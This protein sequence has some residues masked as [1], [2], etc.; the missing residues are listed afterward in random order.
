MTRA[1]A[2]LGPALLAYEVMIMSRNAAQWE[3][4]P[5]LKDD[6]YVNAD[7]YTDEELYREELKK[8][9]QATW[10]FA[11]HES[12]IASPNDFRTLDHAGVPIIVARD[13]DGKIRAFINSCSHR[14]AIVLREPSTRERKL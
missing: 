3:K 7:I 4:K 10:K 9:K 12:E 13:D 8:V 5:A 2:T 14:S 6:E 1:K 11:C